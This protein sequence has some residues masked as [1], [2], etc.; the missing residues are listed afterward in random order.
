[1]T[2]TMTM[3]MTTTETTTATERAA[4]REKKHKGSNWT[5]EETR[6]FINLCIE[7]RIIKMMDGKRHK[8]IDIYNSLEPAMKEMGFIKSGAQM[9]IKLKHLKEQYFKCKRNNTGGASRQTFVFYEEM[10]ELLGGRPS[11]EAIASTGIDLTESSN[12]EIMQEESVE[13]DVEE[14]EANVENIENNDPAP[15][16]SSS[17]KRKISGRNTH[18]NLADNFAEVFAKKQGEEL[19]KII[20]N[21]MHM[22]NDAI[23]EQMKNQQKWE[24]EMMEKE[25]Q[26]QLL[27]VNT[28]MKGLG[29]M[30]T[31]NPQVPQLRP[32]SIPLQ[33]FPSSPSPTNNVYLY[34]SPSPLSRTPTPSSPFSISLSPSS[35][36]STNCSSTPLASPSYTDNN[37]K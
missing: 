29:E 23:H 10:E 35:S 4:L 20:T 34:K 37:K 24:Q 8:H 5:E 25:H 17:K 33:T 14:V 15:N 36:T 3:M 9:K 28:F 21:Q 16:N 6:T 2:M 31:N 32:I 1:M 22:F 26:H 19:Q 30:Q 13:E 11:V 12:Q 7:K 27:I 18:M